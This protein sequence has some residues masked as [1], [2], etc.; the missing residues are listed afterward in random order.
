MRYFFP[1]LALTLA[2]CGSDSTSRA[3][4]DSAIIGSYFLASVNGVSV[5]AALTVAGVPGVFPR[6]GLVIA[7]TVY[8]ISVA[9]APTGATTIDSGTVGGIVGTSAL[10]ACGISCDLLGSKGV[11]RVNAPQILCRGSISPVPG[12]RPP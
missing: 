5:P 10:T 9:A 1:L 11:V 12:A 8:S 2:A 6:D 4:G 3:T 7:D